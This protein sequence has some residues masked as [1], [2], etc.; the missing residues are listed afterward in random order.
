[1]EINIKVKVTYYNMGLFRLTFQD[2]FSNCRLF[3][4]SLS[5]K[6]N[7]NQVFKAGEGAGKSGSFFFFSHDKKFII[8]TMSTEELLLFQKLHPNLA[9]HHKK[10]PMSLLAKIV[11]VFSISSSRTSDVHIILMENAL[12]IENQANLKFIFDLKGSLS[13]RAVKGKIKSTTTL[14]DLNFLK[15]KKVN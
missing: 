8:K 3:H 11:G 6:F 7:L 10:N 2:F 5:P 15:A 14:K 4:A 9:E 12:Q 1:M 13:G